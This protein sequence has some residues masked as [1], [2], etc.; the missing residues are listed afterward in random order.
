MV[1]LNGETIYGTRGGPVAPKNWGG[2]T[3]KG[4]TVYMHILSRPETD[5]YIFVDGF[6]Q[7]IRNAVLF[8]GKQEVK[9]RQVPEG[10]FIYTGNITF[11]AVD[12]I[13]E[14]SLL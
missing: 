3:Q 9:F 12:T 5:G 10:T 1:K 11:D 7:K 8:N 2:F 4:K 14:I 6:T 13:V